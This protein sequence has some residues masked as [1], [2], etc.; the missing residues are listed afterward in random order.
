MANLQNKIEPDRDTGGLSVRVAGFLWC[1]LDLWQNKR[2]GWC[3]LQN[4]KE[5]NEEEIGEG[6]RVGRLAGYNLNIF[7]R[8]IDEY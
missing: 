4:K 8:L 5:E 2:G 7:D 6:E 3:F 1:E